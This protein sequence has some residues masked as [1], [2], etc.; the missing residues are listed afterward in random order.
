M[1]EIDRLLEGCTECDVCVAECEFLEKVCKSPRELADQFSAGYFKENPQIPY[2]CNLCNLCERL[3][4]EE[5]NIGRM[6]LEI[7]RQLVAEVLGP[8]PSH[9]FVKEDR[10]WISTNFSLAMPDPDV[11]EVYGVFFPGCILSGYSPSLVMDTYNYLRGKLPGTGIILGCCGNPTYCLGEE[12]EFQRILSELGSNIEKLGASDIV[13]AC[14]LCYSTLK[15]LASFRVTSIYEVMAEQGLP[16]LTNRG[17]WTFSLHDSCPTRYEKALQDSVRSLVNQ[18]GYQ[19]EEMEYSRD[20]TRCC[21]MGGMVS[22]ANLKLSNRMVKRRVEEAKYDILTYCA[23][24]RE[25][26]AFFGKPS[27][28]IL[29]LIF[30]PDWDKGRRNPAKL[31]RELR[32][33]QALLKSQLE[34]T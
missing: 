34:A 20:K 10:E 4:P 31:R 32:E 17:N 33:N 15:S 5:L 25:A 22:Y 9:K 8:L 21:G 7:R 23:S 29:D 30:N 12:G 18:M 14:P 24:C 13:T 19:M 6:C 26:F 27:L 11:G 28:H 1:S 3:C 16:E 2:S